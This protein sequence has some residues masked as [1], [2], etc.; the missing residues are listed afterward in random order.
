MSG[1]RDVAVA[2]GIGSADKLRP[3]DAAVNGAKAFH[4]WAEMLGYET[5]WDQAGETNS[6][7][8]TDESDA[9]TEARL[10]ATFDGVLA[11]TP[12]K[13]IHRIIVYFA[14]HGL[15]RSAGETLWLLSDWYKE[16]YG[17]A[18][19]VL[20]RRLCLYQITQITLITDCCQSLPADMQQ[21]DLDAA[22]VLRRGPLPTPLPTVAVDKFVAAQD[23]YKSYAIPGSNPTGDRC[24]FSE[25]LLRG[26]WGT[27]PQAY[28]TLLAGRVT[29]SSL[30]TYL[31]QEVPKTAAKYK[32]T[33]NPQV[34]PTFPENDNIYF[35]NIAPPPPPPQF[36]PWPDPSIFVGMGVTAVASPQEG[37]VTTPTER[38]LNSQ[39]NAQST[40]WSGDQTGVQVEGADVAALWIDPSLSVDPHPTIAGRWL[41]EENGR[42]LS[43]PASMLVEYS[44]A[45]GVN[46]YAAVALMPKFGV[47]LVLNEGGTAAVRYQGTERDPV[48]EQ[49]VI[50]A[51]LAMNTGGLRAEQAQS[52]ALPLRFGKHASPELGVIAAYL[53]DAA[54][55]VETIWRMANFYRERQQP[56]PYDIAMLGGLAAERRKSELWAK[57][58]A[59]RARTPSAAHASWDCGEITGGWSAVGGDW[60]W[61]KQGWSYLDWPSDVTSPLVVPTLLEVKRSLRPGRFA[62]LNDE[63][64]GLLAAQ[65]SLHRKEVQARVPISAA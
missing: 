41:V 18:Q 35:G 32:L 31:L 3:L 43:R 25:V 28:S 16:L 63:G 50:D 24:I 51:L 1:Q 27:E 39:L 9:V 22:G 55:D 58:P 44:T 12:I 64:A 20:K 42:P 65:F 48:T 37:T 36:P 11:S 10:R 47:F 40:E 53:Y 13:P 46:L 30:G 34:A 19:E 5:T 59:I 56:I 38:K 2:I 33:L 8:L 4:Q 45:T 6:T 23:G 61:M 60:P 21:S 26:L 49:T 52:L 7:L 57:V 54:E 14:G 15:I 29:S 62:T 17:V